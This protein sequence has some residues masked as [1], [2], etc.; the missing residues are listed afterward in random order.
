M[1]ARKPGQLSGGQRQRV[2]LARAIV[3]EP[4]VLLLDEP[5][6]ALDARLRQAMQVELKQLQRKLGITFV[7]VTHDQSEALAMSDRVA[8]MNEGKIEQLGP[9]ADVYRLPASPFV[10][11]FIGN[12]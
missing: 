12:A 10:A 4:K 9:P 8:V 6:A 11:R 1:E 5:L 3:R 7:F 2:A